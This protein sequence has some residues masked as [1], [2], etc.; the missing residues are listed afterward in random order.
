MIEDM[1]RKLPLG[2]QDFV[3]MREGDY[4]YVD[5][6]ALIHRLVAEGAEGTFFLSRPRRF[7]KSLLCS[8][9]A[10]VF[11]GRRGL[12]AGL[13]IDALPWEWKIS[14]VVRIDLNVGDY[15]R[16]VE[17]LNITLRRCLNSC[18]K[19]Y[20]ISIEE[21]NAGTPSDLFAFIMETLHVK[22]NERVV[23]VIDEYDKPLLNTLD[24]KEV[25]VEIRSALKAFY[26]VLKSCDEH[27]RLAFLTGITKFAQ[28]SVFSDL[29]QINDLS[30]DPRY[31]DL[32]GVTQEELERD[33]EDEI[34]AVVQ[35]GGK[36]RAEYLAAIKRFYN[37][38]R[39]SKK[40]LT[41][42]N[43]FGLLHHFDKS[44][45]F[46]PYWYISGTPTF[47]VNLIKK[48][49]IDITHLENNR[50]GFDSFSKYD[51]ENMDAVS[52]LYQTGYLTIA[53][54]DEERNQLTLDYP[55]EEVRASFAQSLSKEYLEVTGENLNSFIVR[56]TNAIYDGDV[57][58]V[59]NALKP[60]FASINYD[61]I[62][63]S[64][65][66][67]QTVIH[68]VF[69]MLGMQCRSEV[70]IAAGRI[71]TL[72]ETKRNV[73]CFEFKLRGSAETALKQIDSKEYLLPW[74][75][76]GKRLFKV[77]VSFNHKKRNI[78]AWKSVVV[79]D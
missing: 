10:A 13:A 23:V 60:F 29:N 57:D 26:G 41:V 22:F 74:Q 42:Y 46:M 20:G 27:L 70:R 1:K 77:G 3:K 59:M 54:Y 8:T 52:L 56:F 35:S 44:G 69:K 72:V 24:H 73:F 68:L 4:R 76:S 58:A 12:F 79:E 51:S 65:N 16:G 67:Y 71:D 38:Y 40:P 75:G 28:V 18:A 64:E 2:V 66:Y 78:G 33:F 9:I 32:C 6:T 5:K 61:L 17:E 15:P 14:P 50:V 45:E 7:G 49:Y 37:G 34:A 30:F 21:D 63:E 53:D 25:H 11:E 43:P 39:F 47:L 19:K 36:D 55:N 62:K 31:A 48:Q